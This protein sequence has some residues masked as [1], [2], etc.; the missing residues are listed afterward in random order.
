MQEA[1][2]CLTSVVFNPS[3]ASDGLPRSADPDTSFESQQQQTGRHQKQPSFGQQQNYQ[4]TSREEYDEPADYSSGHLPPSNSYV[5]D[6]PPRLPSFSDDIGDSNGLRDGSFSQPA[7]D[8]RSNSLST[9]RG[10]ESQQQYASSAHPSNHPHYSVYGGTSTHDEDEA[11]D[12][13]ALPL[14]A[15]ARDGRYH[16]GDSTASISADNRSSLAYMDEPPD[17]TPAAVHTPRNNQVE[18]FPT[19]PYSQGPPSEYSARDGTPRHGARVAP[20]SQYDYEENSHWAR[21][22]AT[23]A[24]IPLPSLPVQPPHIAQAPEHVTTPPAISYMQD[25][26]GKSRELQD[27]GYMRSP[28][29]MQQSSFNEQARQPSPSRLSRRAP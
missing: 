29:T 8:D 13:P 23:A 24:P 19:S 10:L 4:S 25:P 11:G 6:A 27:P 2:R 16:S 9:E 7:T 12:I 21:N 28:E 18:S 1:Q 26:K 3:T 15:F 5:S 22:H 14:P 20:D 17:S